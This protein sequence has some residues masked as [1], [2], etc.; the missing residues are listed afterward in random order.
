MTM[1]YSCP[2]F[3]P[4]DDT[5]YEAIDARLSAL[6]EEMVDYLPDKLQLHASLENPQV[7]KV[8]SRNLSLPSNE[9]GA[10]SSGMDPQIHRRLALI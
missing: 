3:A 1:C 5:S 9:N 10:T 4:G 2:V 7:I 8:S 6:T